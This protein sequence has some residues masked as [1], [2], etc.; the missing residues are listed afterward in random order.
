MCARLRGMRPQSVRLNALMPGNVDTAMV[1][2]EEQIRTLAASHPL[3]PLGRP[4]GEAAAAMFL[5]SGAGSFVTGTAV[6]VDG[7][8]MATLPSGAA[9]AYN[10]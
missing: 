9:L 8:L 10:T 1:H 2:G 5:A 3:R 6:S 4:D 7:G